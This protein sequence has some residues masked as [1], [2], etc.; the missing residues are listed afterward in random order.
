MFSKTQPQLPGSAKKQ[1]FTLI[2]LL[3]VIA[4]IAILAAI[5]FP[6]FAQAREKAR[7]TSCLSNMK[8]ISLAH[9]MY[10]QDYDERFAPSRSNTPPNQPTDYE[11]FG[12]TAC[13]AGKADSSSWRAEVYPYVKN[14]QAYICPD[15]EQSDQYVEGCQEFKLNLHRS[16]AYNGNLFNTTGGIKLS[17]L[18]RPAN[19]MLILESRFEY[20]DLGTNCYPGWYGNAVNGIFA[21]GNFQ[22]HSGGMGNWGLA[23]GHCKALKHMAV[24][25]NAQSGESYWRDEVPPYG[26][27]NWIANLQILIRQVTEYNQ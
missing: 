11:N 5:L 12:S 21:K 26:D 3:V 14:T 20:P 10:V 4:I 6:V 22:T 1:G 27:N 16:Y 24:A 2:E 15:N 7:Q 25:G 18:T 9:L 19:D 13:S 23:D 8:Q 17:T